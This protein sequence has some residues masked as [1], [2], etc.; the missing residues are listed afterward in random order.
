MLKQSWRKKRT[1]KEIEKDKEAA[2]LEKKRIEMLD[3]VNENLK[4]QNQLLVSKASQNSALFEQLIA[5]GILNQDF[6]GNLK[7][8]DHTQ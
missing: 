4:I 3:E 7:L 6:T 2:A 1:K 8:K 5:K